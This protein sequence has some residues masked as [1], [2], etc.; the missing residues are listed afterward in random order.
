MN[1]TMDSLVIVGLYAASCSLAGRNFWDDVKAE[2]LRLHS[3]ERG[4]SNSVRRAQLSI[5][6]A[7][8]LDPKT[9]GG[10]LVGKGFIRPRLVFSFGVSTFDWVCFVAV[11]MIEPIQ[12]FEQQIVC[13]CEPVRSKG[14]LWMC[15]FFFFFF[16]I[17]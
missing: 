10:L 15:L 11:R 6:V 2:T 16:S 5:L 13:H 14:R 9:C 8:A 3:H 7:A 17:T 4:I 12:F 1:L